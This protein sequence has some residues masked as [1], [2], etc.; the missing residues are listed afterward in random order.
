MHTH[1]LTHTHTHMLTQ[2]HTHTNTH[3]HARMHART[4]TRAR[5]HTHTHTHTCILGPFE[6]NVNFCLWWGGGG[7]VCG[8]FYFSFF[9]WCM[10]FSFICFFTWGKS[11]VTVLPYYRMSGYHTMLFNAES[12]LIPALVFLDVT[13]TILTA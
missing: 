12:T 8:F 11:S 2:T 5:A 13:V 6:L 10:Y 4:H 9:F 1:T 3:T 7:F